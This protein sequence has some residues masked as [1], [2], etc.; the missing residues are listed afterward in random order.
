MY[1]LPEWPVVNLYVV[2]ETKGLLT[3]LFHA[4]VVILHLVVDRLIL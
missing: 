3:R 4:I 1:S 2:P